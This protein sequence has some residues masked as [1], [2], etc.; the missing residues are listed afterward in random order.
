MIGD[1]AWPDVGGTLG[2]RRT[3]SAMIGM[4]V[5]CLA[6]AKQPGEPRPK[7]RKRRVLSERVPAQK[8]DGAQGARGREGTAQ[9]GPGQR[10]AGDVRHRRFFAGAA[11]DSVWRLPLAATR[12]RCLGV[13]GR[14]M[15]ALSG[16]RAPLEDLDG[17][18]DRCP[19]LRQ[20][21]KFLH[22]G[23]VLPRK[24]GWI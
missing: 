7:I 1:S 9:K 23:F 8:A 13:A 16:I 14:S 11:L 19:E 10:A 15:L 22:P 4:G 20:G 5:Y 17:S 21:T 24:T 2:L 3:C 18:L 12:L 6:T